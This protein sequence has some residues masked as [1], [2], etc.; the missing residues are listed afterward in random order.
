MKPP[1]ETPITLPHDE[2]VDA[3]LGG[4]PELAGPCHCD[5]EFGEPGLSQASHTI[6]VAPRRARIC[7][8]EATCPSN[9]VDANTGGE[10]APPMLTTA[11]P[12]ERPPAKTASVA[13]PALA[14]CGLGAA[15]VHVAVERF[16]PLL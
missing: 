10:S 9:A 15:A 3:A 11:T 14:R 7:P 1:V 5:A 8:F 13:N 6:A 4:D 16:G 12:S 2:C